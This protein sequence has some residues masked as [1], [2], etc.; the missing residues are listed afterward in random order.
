MVSDT[1]ALSISLFTKLIGNKYQYLT[2]IYDCEYDHFVVEVVDPYG[3]IICG[4]MG[5]T[6]E[7][8]ID[9]VIKELR[10]DE[11]SK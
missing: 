6:I 9:D 5:N 4:G 11:E 3:E 2:V 8:A 10:A 7:D 1:D